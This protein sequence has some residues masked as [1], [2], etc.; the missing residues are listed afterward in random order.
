MRKREKSI[1]C[2]LSKKTRRQLEGVKR[3]R[4]ERSDRSNVLNRLEHNKISDKEFSEY[5]SFFSTPKSNEKMSIKLQ[6]K[7]NVNNL[8]GI[9]RIDKYAE[10]MARLRQEID[11]NLLNET[12]SNSDPDSESLSIVDSESELALQGKNNVSKLENL[13]SPEKTR[14]NKNLNKSVKLSTLSENESQIK[15]KNGE[16]LQ[17]ECDTIESSN[18]IING[19]NQ[20]I[21]P[22]ENVNNLKMELDENL[23]FIN[24]L[25]KINILRDPINEKRRLE[26]PVLQ[27]E[28]EIVDL[29][30]R[31]DIVVISGSTGS[32]KTTQLPQFL[33]EAGFTSHGKIIGIT[34]PRRIAAVNMCR[35]VLNEMSTNQHHDTLHVIS[36]KSKLVGYKIRFD[37]SKNVNTKIL[38]M[39][40][41][42]LLKE[43][44]YD[45]LLEKFSVIIIDEAHERTINTDLLIGFLVKIVKLRRKRNIPLKV[46]IMSATLHLNELMS[47]N[48]IF[49]QKNDQ[50]DELPIFEIKSNLFPVQVHFHTV[51]IENYLVAAFD[52]V[53]QINEDFYGTNG[54]VLI[55]VTGRREIDFLTNKI[56]KELCSENLLALPLYASLQQTKQDKIF[57]MSN[58][59]NKR[60]CVVATNVAETSITINNVK[61][62]IDTGKVKE[63]VYN[64]ISG[65]SHF[66]VNWI[67]KASALQRTG[68]AGRTCPGIC[69]RLYSSSVFENDF[70]DFTVPQILSVQ[71]DELVLYLKSLNILHVDKFPFVTAPD[72]VAIKNSEKRLGAIGALDKCKNFW[73]LNSVYKISNVGINIIK[74]PILPAYA[75]I[76]Y[77]SI[78]HNL[79]PQ[80]LV[81]IGSIVVDNFFEPY[82]MTFND[83]SEEKQKLVKEMRLNIIKNQKNL[84][85]KE[86]NRYLF[87]DFYR[88]L[89]I[90]SLI[91][92]ENSNRNEICKKYGVRVKAINEL[93]TFYENFI[94]IV[95]SNFEVNN[96]QF[97][98]PNNE[99]CLILRKIMLCGFPQNVVRRNNANPSGNFASNFKN[100]YEMEMNKNVNIHPSSCTFNQNFEYILY[101]KIDE[102]SKLY[103]KDI[104]CI[105]PSWIP[106]Y[107]VNVCK[108]V[109]NSNQKPYWCKEK[110]D[111]YIRV[112]STYGNNNWKLPIVSIKYPLNMERYRWLGY[113]LLNGLVFSELT[114]FVNKLILLPIYLTQ[115]FKKIDDKYVNFLRKLIDDEINSK[116]KLEMKWKTDPIYLLDDYIFIV[117]MSFYSEVVKKGRNVNE[118]KPLTICYWKEFMNNPSIMY[119][120]FQ[121][122]PKNLRYDSEKVKVIG[123]PQLMIN[124]IFVTNTQDL[125]RIKENLIGLPILM[126]IWVKL[127]IHSYSPVEMETDLA[128]LIDT[129]HP[130]IQCDMEKGLKEIKTCIQ[131]GEKICLTINFEQS[132]DKWAKLVSPITCCTFTNFKQHRAKLF[133][134]NYTKPSQFYQNVVIWNLINPIWLIT[135]PFYKLFRKIR[136]KD[137]V[138]KPKAKIVRRF[139]FME[140]RIVETFK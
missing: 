28:F 92:Q 89:H 9:E 70:K 61:F 80:V 81:I 60:L 42:I 136:C 2:G 113:Y 132:I 46:I 109:E 96:M 122:L 25:K 99:E 73:Q 115:P 18:K 29:I 88:Y 57:K 1:N 62:I 78:G 63:K 138:I 65:I 41:G 66:S 116:L 126:K 104:I 137:V 26:L 21:D 43:M 97:Y 17:K 49:P 110:Q 103:I 35:R 120:L 130:Y 37:S 19:E 4:K 108:I 33:Y 3:R 84:M 79:V 32:G 53:C 133:I 51:T 38:F 124:E 76:I 91:Y 39:T 111:V 71:I 44:Q 95:G 105:D 22:T 24:S 106:I 64:K 8:K 52:Q 100:V 40:D 69:F 107:A 90:F 86:Y 5:K 68:R 34:E 30:Y 14:E 48:L 119:N 50:M 128:L 98:L 7:E 127:D 117:M 82:P 45:F 31:H 129:S 47:C 15:L 56:N 87:G 54:H 118:I 102:T 140:D 77:E 20:K 75:R 10:K 134:T 27:H 131:K 74:I 12:K 121:N 94:L 135:Y 72:R 11:D 93:F 112:P 36:K 23:N 101:S 16:Y 139:F 13:I 58:S 67:S 123:T 85:G 55:F 83:D 125:D 6:T 59:K 114:T